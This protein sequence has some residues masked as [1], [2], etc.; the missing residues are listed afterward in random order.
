MRK[1]ALLVGCGKMTDTPSGLVAILH[2][3]EV[4]GPKSVFTPAFVDA[5]VG[6][7]GDLNQDGYITGAELGLH[8]QQLVPQYAKQTPQFDKHPEYDL[9]R[10]DFVFK[11]LAASTTGPNAVQ[12][13]SEGEFS[14]ITNAQKETAARNRGG[15][16]TGKF[17]T[18]ESVVAPTS[19]RA[20]G[21]AEPAP[22]LVREAQEVLLAL[23]YSPGAADGVMGVRTRGA[24]RK[25]QRQRDLPVSGALTVETLRALEEAWGERGSSG[26]ANKDAESA[27]EEE[28]KAIP[29][30]ILPIGQD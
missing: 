6:A 13:A 12:I 10:G 11:A 22:R 15:S 29:I 28:D 30:T 16:P 7:K 2:S 24:L 8:L 18:G 4:T 9:A 26:E 25:F 14:F 5:I 27:R 17:A 20:G 3:D 1:K 21:N 19:K 23:G